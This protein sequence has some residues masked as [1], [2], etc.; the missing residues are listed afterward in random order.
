LIRCC[1]HPQQPASN[2]LCVIYLIDIGV[3]NISGVKKLTSLKG[4]TKMTVREMPNI[5]FTGEEFAQVRQQIAP[6]IVTAHSSL[7]TVCRIGVGQDPEGQSDSVEYVLALDGDDT[8][9]RL[10]TLGLEKIE[11][12]DDRAHLIIHAEGD[13]LRRDAALLGVVCQAAME[14]AGVE[15]AFFNP[16]RDSDI[17]ATTLQQAGAVALTEGRFEFRAAA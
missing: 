1:H 14:H 4:K 5:K 8:K 12:R 9:P 7:E 10:A 13:T 11:G 3:Y 16:D 15:A 2:G 6:R 17:P